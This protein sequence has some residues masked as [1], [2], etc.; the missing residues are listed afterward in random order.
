MSRTHL[1]VRQQNNSGILP[2]L[3]PVAPSSEGAASNAGGGGLENQ[4]WSKG[5]A[6]DC[7]AL[8]IRYPFKYYSPTYTVVIVF[9]VSIGFQLHARALAVISVQQRGTAFASHHTH[10]AASCLLSRTATGLRHW[11]LPVWCC[12]SGVQLHGGSCMSRLACT[13]AAVALC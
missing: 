11:T 1:A 8:V 13:G 12:Y 2:F 3:P 4:A 9:C 10:H 7:F 5:R 6:P